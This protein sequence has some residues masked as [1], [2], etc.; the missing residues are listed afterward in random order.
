M[1]LTAENFLNLL[2]DRGVRYSIQAN[3]ICLIHDDSEL[4]KKIYA[5][6]D[7]K[8]EFKAAVIQHINIQHGLSLKEFMTDAEGAGVHIE[9]VDTFTLTFRGGKDTAQKR[10]AGILE[11]NRRLKAVVIL[12]LAAKNIDFLDVIQE[13]ACRRWSDGYTDSLLMA[14]LCNLTRTGETIERDADGQ[15]I[16]KPKTDWDAEISHLSD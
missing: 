1:K 7:S 10:I 15:I 9:L 13:C 5:L 12:S 14:V 8:P 6:I 16:L 2:S 11:R 3:D 4:I